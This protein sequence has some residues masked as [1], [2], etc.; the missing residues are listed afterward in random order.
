MD[1]RESS[2][3]AAQA[4]ERRAA[5]NMGWHD[6]R[7]GMGPTTARAVAEQYG[8]PI[9]DRGLGWDDAMIAVYLNGRE[10]GARGETGRL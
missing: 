3:L 5:F 2:T 7:N 6:A 10:D 9:G 4:A 1:S 8:R